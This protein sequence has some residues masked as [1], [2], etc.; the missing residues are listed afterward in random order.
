MRVKT[1]LMIVGLFGALAACG[2]GGSPEKPLALADEPLGAKVERFRAASGV[3]GLAVIVIDGDQVDTATSGVRRVGAPDLIQRDDVFQMGS[4]TKAVTATLIARLVEQDKLRWDSTL[5]ELFPAWRDQMRPEYRSVTVT[6]LL[7][8][9]A[10]ITRDISDTDLQALLPLLTGDPI[11]DRARTGLWFLQQPPE[12]KPDSKMSYSNIGYLI[13]GLIAEAV[14]HDTYEHLL[15]QQVL[16]PLQ[17]KGAF[18]LP[19]DAGGQTPAGHRLGTRGWQVA[20]FAPF[21]HDTEQFHSWLFAVQA[22]GGLD[23]SAPAYARFLQDQLRGL[24]GRSTLLKQSDFHLM[25]TPVEGYAF[26]W[27][28]VN[29]PKLGAL[30]AHNGSVGTYYSTT[31]LLP[32]QNRAIA[33]MCNCESDAS[34]GRI[35]EFANALSG[36]AVK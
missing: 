36:I 28:V 21:M 15:T 34:N 33:V 1:M 27:V 12:F 18:G 20:D 17:M 9:R 16:Q 26:G 13:V 23:L 32:G 30:S 35:E 31:R 8:H 6:Q 3:P 25:H 29:D 2:G 22:A 24:Q 14:G 4:L 11:A 10:G 7:R 5:A 19:E